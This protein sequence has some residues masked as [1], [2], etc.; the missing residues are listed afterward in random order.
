MKGY[1]KNCGTVDEIKREYH[2]LAFLYHPDKGGDTE[3]MKTINNEYLIAL[4]NC[5][6]QTTTGTDGKTH[7]YT[8]NEETEQEII[9]KIRELIT[10]NMQGVSIELIGRWIWISGDTR[11]YKEELKKAAC[12]YSGKKKAWYFHTGKWRKKGT[13]GSLDDIRAKYG[14]KTY[15]QEQQAQIQ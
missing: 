3:I 15:E 12:K 9:D 1:F 14:Y 8:Y 11:K 13:A 6:G 2:K 4:Q 7:T 10:I 5:D